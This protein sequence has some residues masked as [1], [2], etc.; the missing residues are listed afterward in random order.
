MKKKAEEEAKAKE[1]E[2]K[3]GEEQEMKSDPQLLVVK[4]RLDKL[5][6][7]VK[8]IVVESN[9]KSSNS[10]ENT[11]VDDNKRKQPA[12]VK[13]DTGAT[14]A[15]SSTTKSS[16]SKEAGEGRTSSTALTD[17]SQHDGKSRQ[18]DVKK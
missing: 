5:E 6:E 3:A 9:K 4:E 16:P 12:I 14:D 17:A 7:T 11:Q 10:G 18:N 2:L 8:E 15:S 13:P 1:M